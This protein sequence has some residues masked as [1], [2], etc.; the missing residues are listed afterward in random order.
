MLPFSS[1]TTAKVLYCRTK[2][3]RYPAVTNSKETWCLHVSPAQNENNIFVYENMLMGKDNN[4]FWS[5]HLSYD[6]RSKSI[7]ESERT[8]Q[9]KNL[10]S[11][12]DNYEAQKKSNTTMKYACTQYL[13]F[14]ELVLMLFLIPGH[15]QMAESKVISKGKN[16]LSSMNIYQLSEIVQ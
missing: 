15:S 16:A 1:R 14:Y 13:L 12:L 3:R 5:L 10:I 2:I 4:Y 8:E 11:V 7:P 6:I 9:I